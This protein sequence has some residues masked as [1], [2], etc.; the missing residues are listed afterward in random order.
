MLTDIKFM[1]NKADII[2]KRDFVNMVFDSNLYY[3]EGIYRTP[4]MMNI[5]S[6]NHL[7]MKDK[8]YLIYEKKKG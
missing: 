7:I 1:Y 3:Q 8:G 2:Q 5:F 4:T 6:N